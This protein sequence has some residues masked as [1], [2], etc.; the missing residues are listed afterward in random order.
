MRKMIL[1]LDCGTG[2]DSAEARMVEEND[3][4]DWKVGVF[5]NHLDDEAWDQAVQHAESYGIYPESTRPDD[6]DPEDDD[7][8]G[9]GEYSVNIEGWWEEYNP[10]KHDGLSITGIWTWK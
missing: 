10:E 7:Q 4:Q 9:N 2:M 1:R 6:S 8:Y 3:Y 5:P